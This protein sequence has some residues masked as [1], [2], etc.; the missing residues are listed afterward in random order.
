MEVFEVAGSGAGNMGRVCV[1]LGTAG[2]E[3]HTESAHTESATMVQPGQD[4]TQPAALCFSSVVAEL[5]QKLSFHSKRGEEKKKQVI[6]PS[7]S[8]LAFSPVFCDS[9]DRNMLCP[10]LG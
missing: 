3:A 5:F 4:T 6:S 2:L 8:R 1:R 10:A 9:M 7:M